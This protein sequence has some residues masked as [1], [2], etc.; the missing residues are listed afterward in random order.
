VESFGLYATEHP[1]APRPAASLTA[2]V[3]GLGVSANG[4]P[5]VELEGGQ[6]WELDGSDPVLANGDAVTITRAAFGSFLLRTDKGRT[7]R[8]RRLR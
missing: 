5:T 2:R 4:R 6:L 7:H 3:V 8:V 1:R